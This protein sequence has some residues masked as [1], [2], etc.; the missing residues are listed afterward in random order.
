MRFYK[1]LNEN[2]D[3]YVVVYSGR[4]QPF[5]QGHY[6]VY[7]HLCNKFGE[8][9]VY[10]ATSDKVDLPKSP[11]NFNEKHRIIT[12]LFPVSRDRVIKV[13]N[14]YA[15][16]EVLNNYDESY[17]YIAVVGRKDADRLVRGKYFEEYQDGMD[18]VGYKQG[19][20]TYIAPQSD[21]YYQGQPIS[22][23]LV[24]E[25]FREASEADKKELFMTLYPKWDEQ[26]F[27]LIMEKLGEN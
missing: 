17:A 26:I 15:P 14:P 22:G 18:L 1:Y 9:S 8:K 16:T 11:F 12:T 27:K 23:T 25:T 6:G 20:Y 7:Q 3:N 13:K 24:R 2:I 10:I 5:H 19:G 4:F 21:A